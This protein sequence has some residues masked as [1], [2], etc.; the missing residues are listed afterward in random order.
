MEFSN[1]LTAKTV[2]GTPLLYVR[3]SGKYAYG[4]LSVLE[5]KQ[6]FKCDFASYSIE[7]KEWYIF[8]QCAYHVVTPEEFVLWKLEQE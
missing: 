8:D 6:S 3:V 7:C 1:H 2:L 5:G 4:T